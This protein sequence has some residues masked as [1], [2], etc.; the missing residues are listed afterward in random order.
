MN[1]T[2]KVSGMSCEGC[3]RAVTGAI[4]RA[5]PVADVRVDLERGEV[6]ITG[7]A[8]DDTVAK[9]VTDAG[10]TFDGAVG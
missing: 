7:T 8:D 3:V 1:T 10:F 4:K 2:Y 9:A 5:L 6:T